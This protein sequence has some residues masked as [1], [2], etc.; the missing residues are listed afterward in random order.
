MLMNF[1]KKTVLPVV[2]LSKTG[3]GN[4]MGKIQRV[5]AAALAL[6]TY[7]PKAISAFIGVDKKEVAFVLRVL[8]TNGWDT[9]ALLEET[10]LYERVDMTQNDN[11]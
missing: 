5:A 9:M 4:E 10:Q 11:V 3:S 7:D 2:T 8:L 6:E 1:D